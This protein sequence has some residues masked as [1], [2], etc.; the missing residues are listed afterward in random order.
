[1]L[2]DDYDVDWEVDQDETGR[3]RSQIDEIFDRP[4]RGRASA[5]HPHRAALRGRS[6]RVRAG[7]PAQATH[8]C[9][10]PVERPSAAGTIRHVASTKTGRPRA[11]RN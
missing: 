6:A 1:L 3:D 5:G 2:E 10:S 4:A 9:L 8:V 7:Q 11:T